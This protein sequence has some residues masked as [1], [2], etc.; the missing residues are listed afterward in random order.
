MK[1][2]LLINAGLALAAAGFIAITTSTDVSAHGYVQKPISRGYQAALE[3]NTLGW[4]G[5]FNKYGKV[6]DDPQSLEAEQGY[7]SKGPAD[8][9]IASADGAVDDFIMDTQTSSFWKKQTIYT[10]SN[11]FTWNYTADH[12]TTKWHYY[13]TK[14]GWNPNKPLTRSSFELIGTVSGNGQSSSKKPTHQITIPSNRVGYHVILAVWDVADTDNAFY[15]VIDANILPR[16]V[17][18]DV[19]Q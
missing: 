13:I 9:R 15:N 7:P 5:A 12:P 6:I 4:T 11:S 16:S 2:S 8:G 10:G 3:K 17:L 19:E 1:K 18:S 14:N